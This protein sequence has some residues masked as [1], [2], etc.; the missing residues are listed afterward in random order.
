MQTDVLIIGQ[1][2]CGSF[3]SWYLLAQGKE[4]IVID[5]ERASSPSRVAAGLINPVTGRRMVTAWMVEELF[6]FANKAYTDF[7]AQLGIQA[8]SRK[9]VVDLFPNPFMRES[10]LHKLT[11]GN[12]YIH[13]VDDEM[14]FA[15]WFNYEFGAGLIGPAYTAYLDRLL[16]A[17]RAELKQQSRLQE[18][19]FDINALQVE[20]DEIKY[21]GIH[22]RQIIFCDGPAGMHNPFFQALPFSRN[23][24]EALIVEIPELPQ[25]HTYKKSLLLVPLSEPE[26]FWFGSSNHWEFEDDKPTPAF[27]E[28]GKNLLQ[29]LLKIPFKVVDH[30]AGLRP[31]TLERRPFVGF[32]P[33]HPSVGLL[34]GMGTKGCSLAPYFAHQ[35]AQ[36]I[37]GNTSAIDPVVDVKRFRR[38]LESR[39]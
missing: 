30:R 10:F 12:E 34:N 1:G 35:L 33:L 29:Q 4:V 28:Q 18:T 7:G 5:E 16:P 15:N 26:L 9:D 21:D 17:W 6:P 37:S 23:K 24:G 32:H 14:H 3:L 25:D 2:I 27:L 11:E 13:R 22:A 31:A 8:F 39:M 20:P 19:S 38:I 36:Y